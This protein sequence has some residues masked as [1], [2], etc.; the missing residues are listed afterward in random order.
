MQRREDLDYDKK[1]IK[2]NFIYVNKPDQKKE[3]RD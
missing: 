2:T 3:D 1:K